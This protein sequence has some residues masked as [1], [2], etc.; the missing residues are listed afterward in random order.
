VS[1]D[2]L[3]STQV[4]VKAPVF[5]LMLSPFWSVRNV[6]LGLV[7]HATPALHASAADNAKVFILLIYNLPLVKALRQERR[8]WLAI[9]LILPLVKFSHCF[10]KNI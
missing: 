8:L 7:A 4:T 6:P 5:V 2:I 1:A 3:S 10:Y 9:I